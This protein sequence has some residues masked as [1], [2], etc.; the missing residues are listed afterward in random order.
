[1]VNLS[2][3]GQQALDWPLPRAGPYFL[4]RQAT[5]ASERMACLAVVF[6]SPLEPSALRAPARSKG[7]LI[8]ETVLS[9]PA[10]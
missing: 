3:T 2:S 1:M 6:D 9:V 8:A 7:N 5:R 4:D 10:H